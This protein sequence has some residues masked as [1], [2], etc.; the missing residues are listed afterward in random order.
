[1]K[2]KSLA[3]ACALLGPPALSFSYVSVIIRVRPAVRWYLRDSSS[4]GSSWRSIGSGW[5]PIVCRRESRPV[6]LPSCRHWGRR[7]RK[8]LSP[9]ACVVHL[10]RLLRLVLVVVV[11]MMMMEPPV[12]LSRERPTRRR[13]RGGKA[14]FRTLVVRFLGQGDAQV[15]GFI[16]GADF[17][18]REVV[19]CVLTRG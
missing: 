17:V 19:V 9:G 7:K 14:Q 3:R 1:M 10:L 11:M 18:I 2:N 5:I 8:R 4:S 16:R 13:P 6:A 12:A 15:P